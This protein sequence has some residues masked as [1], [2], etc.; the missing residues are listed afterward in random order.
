MILSTEL[1]VVLEARAWRWR[2]WQVRVADDIR[3]TA[4]ELELL[5]P[6]QR[7]WARRR[8]ACRQPSCVTGMAGAET[9]VPSHFPLGESST[10]AA[11]TERQDRACAERHR[12]PIYPPRQQD[13][14]EQPE[15][16]VAAVFGI[17]FQRGGDSGLIC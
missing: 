11:L 8:R 13:V 12:P 17:N 3:D 7:S 4:G 2:Q 6:W 5:R 16:V 1:R 15:I 9:S 10:A 14:G